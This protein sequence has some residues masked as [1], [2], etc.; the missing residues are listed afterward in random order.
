[1]KWSGGSGWTEWG[2]IGARRRMNQAQ[3]GS[4]FSTGSEC[5]IPTPFLGLIFLDQYR[6]APVIELAQ[7]QVDPRW[8]QSRGDPLVG[9]CPYLGEGNTS[10]S[11][12]PT[13]GSPAPLGCSTSCVGTVQLWWP[14]SLGLPCLLGLGYPLL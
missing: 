8:L 11:L 5:R 12:D 14:G 10:F 6:L 3:E 4:W 2:M 7:I 1:M 9:R 13:A